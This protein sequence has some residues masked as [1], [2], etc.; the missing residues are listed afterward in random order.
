[1]CIR[2]RGGCD[3]DGGGCGGGWGVL[4]SAF[5]FLGGIFDHWV[6]SFL[7]EGGVERGVRGARSIPL[8]CISLTGFAL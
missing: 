7:R 6:G 2:D 8:R 5:G 1:M 3:G 4:F